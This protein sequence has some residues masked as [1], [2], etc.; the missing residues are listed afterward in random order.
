MNQKIAILLLLTLFS[1]TLSAQ[2]T[3]DKSGRWLVSKQDGKPFF[4]LGD[5][6]W[7]LFH[8]LTRDEALHYLNSRKREGF[9][10]IQCV[11][12]AELDGIRQPNMQGDR[13]FKDVKRLTWDIT[14]GNDPDDADQYDYW[15]HVDFVIREAAKRKL[16][17]GLLPTWGDKVVPGAAGPVL[18]NNEKRAYSYA[19]QLA[20]RYRDQWNIIWILGGDRQ[21]VEYK[22]ER[23]TA[24]YR[25]VWRAMA[26]AIEEVCGSEAFIAYHPRGGTSTSKNLH[27]EEWLDMHAIQSSHGSREVKV[28]QFVDTTRN[29]PIWVGDT[30]IGWQ[31]ALEAK[32]ANHIHHL[33]ELMLSHNDH[34]RVMDQSLIASDR[35]SDYTDEIIATRNRKGSYAMIYLPQPLPVTVNMQQLRKGRRVVSWFNPVTGKKRRVR[36]RIDPERETFTPPSQAE[37]DWVLLIDVR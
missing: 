30:I 9:N 34:D 3:P 5:T 22:E 18:F 36:G 28:W 6:G 12:L 29:E 13:P 24:D 2:I 27:R 37:R 25:P 33:K 20:E 16:Y 1:L 31:K 15:D 23:I 7:E 26:R 19:R 32:A 11:A 8:R 14:P 35:G 4:W 10:V 17:I 21:S